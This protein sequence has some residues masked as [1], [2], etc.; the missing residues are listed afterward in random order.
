M[1]NFKKWFGFY[2]NA[3]IHVA[4][5]AVSFTLITC[6][7]FEI[8]PN[9]AINLFVFFATIS[10]YNFVKYFGANK[11][12]FKDLTSNVNLIFWVTVCCLILAGYF[13]ISFNIE[14]LALI[15]VAGLITWFY[16]FPK[17][18]F[19]LLSKDVG[20]L[21][22]IPGLKVYLVALVWSIITFL[23]PI[24]E[25]VF[26]ITP[27]MVISFAQRFLILVVLILPFEIRDLQFDSLKL[28]TIPQ[29]I[30]INNTKL[31]GFLMILAIVILEYVKRQEATVY[32]L[33]LL[34]TLIILAVLL[35]FSRKNSKQIYTGFWVESIPVFWLGLLLLFKFLLDG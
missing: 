10:A 22:M 14:G 2:L 6:Y 21:R 23:L 28:Q 24:V 16:T 29:T 15:V 26:V 27:V 32:R 1:H 4:L 8:K 20:N 11:A 33:S 9:S 7:E 3:S 13:L 30:G 19:G 31:A 5:A 34:S 18:L 17:S 35:F 12:H 25:N